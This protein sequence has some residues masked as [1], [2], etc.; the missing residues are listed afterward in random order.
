MCLGFTTSPAVERI[1]AGIGLVMAFTV[2]TSITSLDRLTNVVPD[3]VRWAI[4]A[5]LVSLPFVYIVLGVAV[6]DALIAL[7]NQALFAV[8]REYKER[9]YRH[10][11]GHFLAGYIVGLPVL[12]YSVSGRLSAVQFV[13]GPGGG[14]GG[15]APGPLPREQADRMTPRG[16]L[17]KEELAKLAVVSLAG[18]VS[19]YVRFGK[20]EGG[21]QDLVQLQRLLALAGEEMDYK[22][23][24]GLIN[25]AVIQAYTI[26]KANEKALVE[27][28]AAL[29]QKRGVVECMQIIE[30]S[31]GRYLDED[32]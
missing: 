28:M 11:A 2:L 23:S 22:E 9:I 21:Y 3:I 25:Y 29:E 26:I 24:Q 27:L 18:V 4:T 8:N 6:P 32:D 5:G 13:G 14:P 10:E 19:E 30:R 17:S 31:G 7:V 20:A 1:E 15:V 16:L 12:Q